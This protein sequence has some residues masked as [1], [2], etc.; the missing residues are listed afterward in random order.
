MVPEVLAV[1]LTQE[2]PEVK[3]EPVVL[4]EQVEVEEVECH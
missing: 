2:V 3:V 4:E 1:Q